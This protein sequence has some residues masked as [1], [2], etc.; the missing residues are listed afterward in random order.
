MLA[1]INEI[2]D[3]QEQE[4]SINIRSE[5]KNKFITIEELQMTLYDTFLSEK[6]EKLDNILLMCICS[7]LG[8]SKLANEIFYDA[9]SNIVYRGFKYGENSQAESELSAKI[10]YVGV[11][12]YYDTSLLKQKKDTNVTA[13]SKMYGMFL[14]TFSMFLNE[15][16]LYGTVMTKD[17]FRIYSEMYRER[18]PEKLKKLIG[19]K[20]FLGEDSK[21]PIYLEKLQQYIKESDIY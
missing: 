18:S 2:R 16:N 9:E 15:Y 3:R 19:D 4:N 6:K 5:Q 17:E 14:V 12:T 21:Q 8:Q 7:M 11:K 1:I 10:F 20:S 13:Y